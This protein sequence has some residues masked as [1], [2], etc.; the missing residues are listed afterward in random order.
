M[1]QRLTTPSI[2]LIL[3]LVVFVSMLGVDEAQAHDHKEQHDHMEQPNV[4]VNPPTFNAQQ[5]DAIPGLSTPEQ[6]LLRQMLTYDTLIFNELHNGSVDTNDWLELRNVSN[7]DIPLDNWQLT[8][9]TGS[10]TVI[11]PFPAGR[12]ILAGEVLLLVNTDNPLEETPQQNP[13]LSRGK[14]SYHVSEDFVL[15][16]SDFALILRSPTA[17]GDIA[18]NYYEDERP[19]PA[20]ELTP[21]TVW[22]RVQSTTSGYRA[23]AWAVSTHRNG[24]GTPGYQP[25][26]VAG[27]LNH[28]GILNIL[29]LVLVASQFG[30][31]GITAADLNS[32]NTVDIRDLVLVANASSN[33]GAAPTAKQSAAVTVN[34]WLQL[35]RQNASSNV[36]TSLIEGFFYARGMQ[37]LEQLLRTLTPLNN[38]TAGEL[39]QSVQPGN[40]DP[41]SAVKTR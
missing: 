15:P 38:R 16:Q 41:L 29:D 25:S 11:I 26:T 8:V 30:T 10:E 3:V 35:A 18:G 9:Q 6:L 39:S 36:Q 21:D 19:E 31:T 4:G 13:P 1:L 32:D 40:M 20:P 2:F 5:A 28:D 22:E 7:I 14:L 37:V 23:E 34:T 17:F 27:D 12:A 24:L 33:V